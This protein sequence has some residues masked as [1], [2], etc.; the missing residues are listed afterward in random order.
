MNKW[1]WKNIYVML[2]DDGKVKIGVSKD[3]SKRIKS[4]ENAKEVKIINTFKTKKCSNPHTVER[5][6]HEL[7]KDNRVFGEWFDLNFEV[8]I[9]GVKDIF[10][11]Y[12]KFE[13]TTENYEIINNIFNAKEEN[14]KDEMLLC[15]FEII[16]SQDKRIDELCKTITKLSGATENISKMIGELVFLL[17]EKF[18]LEKLERGIKSE[19]NHR[20]KL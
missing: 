3:V 14:K 4:I 11:K 5:A 8:A 17:N 2:A 9:N 15:M 12:A 19:Q 1:N 7:F 16:S 10:N 18:E 6:C 13:E 20:S